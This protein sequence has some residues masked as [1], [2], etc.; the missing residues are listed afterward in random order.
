MKKINKNRLVK[1][2][3]I[4]LVLIVV[5][6]LLKVT[7]IHTLLKVIIY[8]LLFTYALKPIY[9]YMIKRGAKKQ[10]SALVLVLLLF[11]LG[12][13]W[14]V[15]L[16]PQFISEVVS[17]KSN[18]YKVFEYINNLLSNI[19][20]FQ[21]NYL[22]NNIIK[23]LFTF[24]RKF[25][26]D[27]IFYIMAIGQ[28]IATYLI[29][30]VF[31][32]YF[33]VD[34]ELFLEKGLYFVSCNKRRI[35]RRVINHIDCILSKYILSQIFLSIL[36]GILTYIILYFLKVKSP[37]MLAIFNGVINIIPFFGPVI[38]AIPSI[39][40][41][42]AT[43]LKQGLWVT[44]WIVIMQ[45]IEGNFLSPKIVGDL[46]NIHPVLVI[47]LLIIGGEVGGFIGMLVAIPIGV[48]VKVIFEDINYYFY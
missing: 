5:Y 39:I 42:C 34:S 35:I 13:V 30:P 19:K 27:I 1:I 28:N 23:K 38:G 43:S 41:A 16:V 8:S 25:I 4:I 29:I 24:G 47:F 20:F 33:L 2:L 26:E 12:I 44:F 6:F 45:Q 17:L 37:L 3:I 46:V 48:I 18:F 40:I 15:V 21:N 11:M 7:F 32:Y 31:V 36:T 22:F 10:I 9:Q 14:M